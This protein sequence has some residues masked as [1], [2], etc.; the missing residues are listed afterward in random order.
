VSGN[1]DGLLFSCRRDQVEAIESDRLTGGLLKEITDAWEQETGFDL[2]FAEYRSIYN[3]S[4]N[5]YF[6]VKADGSVKQKGPFA[7]PWRE[8][9]NGLREQMMKNPQMTICTDAAIAWILDGTP[10]EKTIRAS[11]D[12]RQFVTVVKDTSG[13]S[14]RG[15]Y[16]GKVVRYIWSVDGDPI[17]KGKPTTKGNFPKVPKTGGARPV[18]ELPD[19]FPTDIDYD[20]YVEEARII[21]TKI[22]AVEKLPP[23]VKPLRRKVTWPML[24]GW[25]LA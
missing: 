14:W 24:A 16:L 4:V 23:P 7:N 20:R 9:E 19:E 8:G 15:E 10:L 1:T 21:L 13:S 17:I 25:A 6:A 18:M 5:S 22:G 11:T 12:I 2:E 3:E